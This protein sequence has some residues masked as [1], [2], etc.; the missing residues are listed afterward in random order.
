MII[1]RTPFR[2]SFFG[3]G[4]DYPAWYREHG[5]AVLATT[6]DKYCYIT[7][8]YLP[9]F[10]DHK[11]RILYSHVEMV[12][13]NK[14]IKHPAVRAILERLKIEAGV[15]IHHDGDLPARTGLGSSSAFAVGLLHALFALKNVMPTKMQLAKEAIY[16]EQEALKENV[17]CQDQLH[18]ASGGFNIFKFTN[19][20]ISGRPLEITDEKKDY[21]QHCMMVFFTGLTR[22]ATKVVESQV[23]SIKTGDKDQY[24]SQMYDM[25]FE[26]E[27]IILN[28]TKD[29]MVKKI[30]G[31]LNDSWK[32]KQNLSSSVTNQHINSA[33]TRAVDAGAFGG[34]LA[35]AGGGGFLFFM[36]DPKKQ[37]AVR[38]ALKGFTEVP[39]RFENTGSTIVYT[40]DNNGE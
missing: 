18:A 2:M 21:L 28:E 40:K 34:K 36:V 16:I 4:T 38:H 14:D 1:C 25:V 27:K 39:L 12:N 19:A 5:G 11:S 23:K 6:I 31:L 35:G 17:G 24:L 30:G 8:R 37:N 10:F 9:P 22:Y 29:K 7:A 32:L 33:Y 15:E 26:A 3:G 13:D 20:G